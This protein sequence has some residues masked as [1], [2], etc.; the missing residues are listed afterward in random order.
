MTDGTIK[1]HYSNLLEEKKKLFL[2]RYSQV[3]KYDLQVVLD[4]AID[5][6][7]Y[8]GQEVLSSS[9][10]ELLIPTEEK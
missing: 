9:I 3:D 7:Y 5:L 2:E 6:G 8:I 4:K 1:K 10:Q